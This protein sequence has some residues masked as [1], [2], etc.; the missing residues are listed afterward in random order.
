VST[1]TRTEWNFNF[2]FSHGASLMPR[3]GRD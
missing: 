3:E 1:R 2:N